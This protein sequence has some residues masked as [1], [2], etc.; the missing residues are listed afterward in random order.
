MSS[1]DDQLIWILRTIL[2]N[3]F[4]VFFLSSMRWWWWWWWWSTECWIF[5]VPNPRHRHCIR[6]LHKHSNTGQNSCQHQRAW[7]GQSGGAAI[8]PP[9][10]LCSGEK[11]FRLWQR[12]E[13]H[14][15][16]ESRPPFAKPQVSLKTKHYETKCWNFSIKKIRDPWTER[17]THPFTYIWSL[18]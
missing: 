5:W 10:S 13:D 9:G 15:N 17:A 14:G 2:I 7:G 18:Y 1:H 16:C 4:L 11:H 3:Y 8:E 12:L 6:T